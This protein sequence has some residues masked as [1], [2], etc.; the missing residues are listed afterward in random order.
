[1]KKIKH[2]IYFLNKIKHLKCLRTQRKSSLIALDFNSI[3]AA[4]GLLVHAPDGIF[5][6]TVV[7]MSS[8]ERISYYRSSPIRVDLAVLFCIK[9]GS[10]KESEGWSWS[11]C[12]VFPILALLR[13]NPILGQVISPSLC[14]SFLTCKMRTLAVTSQVDCE[15]YMRDFKKSSTILGTYRGLRCHHNYCY[16]LTPSGRNHTRC[17]MLFSKDRG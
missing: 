16:S 14:L 12:D 7:F 10:D 11:Q 8:W 13:S 1:M 5:I 3:V 17:Y 6:A 9:C 15:D 4:L 2:F